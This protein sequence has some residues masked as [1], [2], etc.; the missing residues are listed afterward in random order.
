MA[1]LNGGFKYSKHVYG[2][3]KES[4]LTS[5]TYSGSMA[6]YF[7]STTGIEFN[8]SHNDEILTQ[9][10]RVLIEPGL[11]IVSIQNR[12]KT[13]TYGAGLR[14]ML[15]SRKAMITPVVSAGYARQIKS[16]ITDYTFE[17]VGERILY[18]VNNPR[19]QSNAMF[20]TFMLKINITKLIAITGSVKT[21]FSANDYNDIKNNLEYEAGISWVLP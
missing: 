10:E 3:N 15:A 11:Y 14:Q 9:N 20:G 4:S 1:E 21:V 7:F 19:E 17:A 13:K 2:S 16:S 6:I 8:Y 18:K 5:R 12:V